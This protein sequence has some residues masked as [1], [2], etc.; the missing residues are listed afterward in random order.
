[1]PQH[2]RL[3]IGIDTELMREGLKRLGTAL[4]QS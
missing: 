3:G 1:M 2:F 4:D